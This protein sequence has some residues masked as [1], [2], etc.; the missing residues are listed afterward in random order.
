MRSTRPMDP[1]FRRDD[2]GKDGHELAKIT[3]SIYVLYSNQEFDNAH[4]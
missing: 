1:D 3:R 4:R 2:D